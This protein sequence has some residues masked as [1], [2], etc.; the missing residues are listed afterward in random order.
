MTRASY[1]S[2]TG[3]R[4]IRL[5]KC[6]SIFIPLSVVLLANTPDNVLN[7]HYIFVM[8]ILNNLKVLL[9]G[10]KRIDAYPLSIEDSRCM[11]QDEHMVGEQMTND[12]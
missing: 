8:A 11:I 5:E 12:Y 1:P 3:S 7:Q 6:G 2:V 9:E 4:F 10:N